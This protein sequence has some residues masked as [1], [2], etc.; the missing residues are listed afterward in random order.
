M[1]LSYG[2][3]E[4][5]IAKVL[6]ELEDCAGA[7]ADAYDND[8]DADIAWRA[9]RAYLKSRERE[10]RLSERLPADWYDDF[11]TING[12]PE[13]RDHLRAR[14]KLETLRAQRAILGARLDGLRTL[15]AGVR[16]AGG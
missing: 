9:K 7:L 16:G 5:E 1:V 6:C 8:A 3:I 11:A 10:V 4:A 15:A 12:A 2:N 14:A 13:L